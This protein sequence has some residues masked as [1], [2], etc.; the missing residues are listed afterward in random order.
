ME[1]RNRSAASRKLCTLDGLRDVSGGCFSSSRQKRRAARREAQA[2][3]SVTSCLARHFGP[4]HVDCFWSRTSSSF[5]GFFV[6][7]ILCSPSR[8]TETHLFWITHHLYYGRNNTHLKHDTK[9]ICFTVQL[10]S[11]PEANRYQGTLR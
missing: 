4:L 6:L 11:G 9:Q 3:R 10:L 1:R 8:L 7:K 2:E 5:S